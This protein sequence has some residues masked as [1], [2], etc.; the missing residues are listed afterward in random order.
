MGIVL[1][2]HFL[3][4]HLLPEAVIYETSAQLKNSSFETV[5]KFSKTLGPDVSMTAERRNS[6]L[7]DFWRYSNEIDAIRKTNI[8][9]DL[10]H[11]CQHLQLSKSLPYDL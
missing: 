10:P 5:Q 4:Y 6:L 1:N 11:V 3:T 2:P 7:E 8:N 9:A